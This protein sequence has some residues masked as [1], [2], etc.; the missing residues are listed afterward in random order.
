MTIEPKD[1]YYL[2]D[3]DYD[4]GY[5]GVDPEKSITDTYRIGI[6]TI[7]TKE[8]LT[9]E[10]SY[11]NYYEDST[12]ILSKVL[13]D[14]RG[15]LV[16]DS[17]FNQISKHRITGLQHLPALFRGL[18]GELYEDYWYLNVFKI[19]KFCDEDRSTINERLSSEGTRPRYRKIV[20]DNSKLL[21]VPE[22]ERLI[23]KLADAK[24]VNI[25]VHQRIKDLFDELGIESIIYTPSEQYIF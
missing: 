6:E 12:P 23:F 16:D 25:F 19:H 21:S 18:D 8:V 24:N 15:I 9:F 3:T 7:E 5:H 11:A 14:R 17:I 4:S 1:Q 20:L 2:I 10:T 13:L 22:E